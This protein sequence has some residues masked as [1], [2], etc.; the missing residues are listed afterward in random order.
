MKIADTGHAFFAVAA[1]DA[2]R[3]VN[4]IDRR[5]ARTGLDRAVVLGRLEVDRVRRTGDRAQPAGHA[6][7]QPVLVPHQHLLAPAF[8]EHRDLLVRIVDRDRLLEEVLE[9]ESRSR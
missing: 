1:E 9:R 4:L 3:L 8:R 5:V 2:A 6:L 7:L